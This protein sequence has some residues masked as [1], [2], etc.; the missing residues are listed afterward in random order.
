MELLLTMLG[1]K[2]VTSTILVKIFIHKKWKEHKHGTKILAGTM[3][4][5]WTPVAYAAAVLVI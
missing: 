1:I 4:C 3:A 2:I 5:L